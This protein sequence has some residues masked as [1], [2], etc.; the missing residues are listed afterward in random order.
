MVSDEF[1]SKICRELG[2]ISLHSSAT[3]INFDEVIYNILS[4]LTDM[5]NLNDYLASLLSTSTQFRKT[6][7]NPT[8][9]IGKTPIIPPVIIAIPQNILQPIT[10]ITIEASANII[11][12][13]NATT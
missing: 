2:K 12:P 9:N 13:I 10:A 6:S 3:E 5:I 8:T 4:K 11:T 7:A 1:C